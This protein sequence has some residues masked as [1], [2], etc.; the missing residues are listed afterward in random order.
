M[1]DP[2]LR[3]LYGRYHLTEGGRVVAR[4]DWKLFPQGDALILRSRI[5]AGDSLEDLRLTLDA[6]WAYRSLVLIRQVPKGTGVTYDG[7][8]GGGVWRVELT[9][10]DGKYSQA[11]FPW[12]PAVE[13]DYRSPM[14][15]GVTVRRLGLAVGEG[16]DIDV[17]FM[18]PET[19]EPRRVRQ[20]YTRLEDDHLTVK[21][22]HFP[23]H[24]YRYEGLT[25]GY[26]GTIWTD[27]LG[28]VLRF[29]DWYEL[30]TFG[31]E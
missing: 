14:F 19:F 27:P 26:S 10:T 7:E 1:V 3:P 20:R 28:T 30:V 4:E 23:C 9:T 2:L 11:E 24:V 22:G 18:E 25:S 8:V 12:S 6:S 15:N 29:E 13:L 21:A 17:I 5:Q 31:R 16:R